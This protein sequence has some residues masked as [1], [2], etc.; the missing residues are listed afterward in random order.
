MKNKL[1]YII[2]TLLMLISILKFGAIDS[3]AGTLV[4]GSQYATNYE[5]FA[6]KLNNEM[7]LVIGFELSYV[8]GYPKLIDEF[9][10]NVVP[11]IK[12]GRTL[13]PVRFI[14]ESLNADVDWND[15]TKTITITN[16]DTKISLVIG[17]K[18]IIINGKESY[19]DVPAQ[20]IEERTFIPLR[21]LVEALNKKVFWDD[22]GLIVISNRDNLIDLKYEQE[23]L[24]TYINKIKDIQK[25][26]KRNAIKT[27]QKTIET[28]A[29]ACYAEYGV[30]PTEAYIEGWMNKSFKSMKLKLIHGGNGNYKIINTDSSI[31]IE[32][33]NFKLY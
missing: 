2:L 1:I 20:I 33:Y 14:S 3:A 7:A 8:K 32:D 5:N 6:A 18:V 24:T 13:V 11:V 4:I 25:E 10:H 30:Y 26:S 28:A 12:D 16:E 21:A 31:E 27:N 9:N 17:S 23:Y 29:K 22:R 15:K 19:L